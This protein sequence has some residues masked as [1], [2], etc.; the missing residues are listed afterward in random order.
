MNAK[1]VEVLNVGYQNT[2]SRQVIP[3]VS[4]YVHVKHQGFETRT[5]KR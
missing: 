4:Q 1:Q 5:K 2:T 3:S